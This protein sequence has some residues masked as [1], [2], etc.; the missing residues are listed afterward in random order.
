LLE[1]PEDS[2]WKAYSALQNTLVRLFTNWRL[3]ALNI[4][5]CELGCPQKWPDF[6]KKNAFKAKAQGKVIP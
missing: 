6:T 2:I 3:L 5:I 4:K 1:V